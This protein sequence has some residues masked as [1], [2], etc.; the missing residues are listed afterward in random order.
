MKLDRVIIKA[1]DYRKS[2]EFYHDILG[3]R[4]KTSW[5]RAD[6]WGALFFCGD[7]LL[8]IIWFPQGSDNA[9]CNYI[10]E[11]SKAELFLSVNNVD[12]IYHKLSPYEAL[13]PTQ[14]E[15]KPW[16]FRLFTVYDPDR[17]KI[18][19]SQPI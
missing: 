12:S 13:E 2:F 5:Q 4:L 8:E 19:F 15:D 10:P 11:H 17:I 3:L 14:P 1:A 7:V 9:D 16:G 6:S 18:I